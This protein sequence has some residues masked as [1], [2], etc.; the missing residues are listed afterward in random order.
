MTGIIRILRC[1]ADSTSV[2]GQV[3]QARIDRVRL[4]KRLDD[5]GLNCRETASAIRAAPEAF[6]EGAGRLRAP[7]A[8]Q[9]STDFRVGKNVAGAYDH[10]GTE[11]TKAKPVPLLRSRLSHLVKIASKHSCR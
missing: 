2:A 11:I 8:T 1:E 3:A 5:D 4:G 10:R 6:I 9:G 7:F